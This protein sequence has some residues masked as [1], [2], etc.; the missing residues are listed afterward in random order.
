MAFLTESCRLFYDFQLDLYKTPTNPPPPPPTEPTELVV[1]QKTIVAPQTGSK[2][3][4]PKVSSQKMSPISQNETRIESL[5]TESSSSEQPQEATVDISIEMIYVIL[6]GKQ[7]TNY[8]NRERSCSCVLFFVTVVI[9]VTLVCLTI[10]VICRLDCC[11]VKT[12]CCRRSR[13]RA[14]TEDRV[15]PHEG[16]PLNKV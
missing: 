13:N 6:I 7:T 10:G 3:I 14:E 2:N 8:T 11:G 9:A 1:T 12:K 4:G 16:I 5:G 15:Q